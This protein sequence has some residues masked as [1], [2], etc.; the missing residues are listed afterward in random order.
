[1]RE[2]A[3][4]SAIRKRPGKSRAR[5]LAVATCLLAAVVV[6]GGHFLAEHQERLL[7]AE[8]A[9]AENER[10]QLVNALREARLTAPRLRLEELATLPLI[11]EFVDVTERW[12]DGQEVREL[13][14]Y[15]QTV[16]N[17]AVAETGLAQITLMGADGTNLLT[18]TNITKAADELSGPALVADIPDINQPS[19][20]SGKLAGFVAASEMAMLTTQ[21]AIAPTSTASV[22]SD[23]D[24]ARSLAI[25]ATTRW[26]SVVAAIAIVMIGLAASLHLSRQ[27]E[28]RS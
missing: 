28:H 5:T 3:D 19:S 1:M 7:V 8:R 25:P 4:N 17:A 12:P 26:L 20:V 21:N 11:S 22:S 24:S 2:R 6:A 15:L 18:A 23:G 14:A 10:G 13:K 16:L 27:S 9:V